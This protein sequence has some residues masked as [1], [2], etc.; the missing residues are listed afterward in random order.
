MTTAYFAHDLAAA[1]GFAAFALAVYTKTARPLLAL[2]GIGVLA[3]LAIVVELPA[4]IVAVAVALHVALERPHLRRLGSYAAGAL[5]GVTPLF[6]F[7]TWAFGS[8]LRT[9]YAYAV[10]E[11]GSSGHD[12]IGANAA[13]VYGLTHPSVG[14]LSVVLPAVWRILRWPAVPH[15]APS[16][17]GVPACRRMAPL[18]NHH[19]LGRG[20][21]CLLDDLC[22]PRGPNLPD[23]DSPDLW[24]TRIADDNHMTESILIGGWSGAA[25]FLVP[26]IAAVLLAAGVVD[27]AVR[28]L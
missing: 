21:V 4:V 3:G 24:L 1:L 13:G 6:L 22:D 5:V 15:P 18:E 27:V 17:L 20:G 7:N 23:V 2:G 19:A 16:I 28:R 12:V 25:L 11:L 26:A 14:P 9:S 8:P 10:K